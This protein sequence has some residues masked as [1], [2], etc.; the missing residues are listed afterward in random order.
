METEF[1]KRVLSENQNTLVSL[2][3]KL[4]LYIQSGD[5]QAFE[6]LTRGVNNIIEVRQSE[7]V[8]SMRENVYH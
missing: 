5:I 2:N 1:T 4:G 8:N 7:L 6:V 3:S